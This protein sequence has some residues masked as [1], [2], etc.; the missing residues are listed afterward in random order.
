MTR[1]DLTREFAG[2]TRY[3]QTVPLLRLDMGAGPAN[4]EAEA[5]GAYGA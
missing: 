4:M 2:R 1:Y 3:P 5:G